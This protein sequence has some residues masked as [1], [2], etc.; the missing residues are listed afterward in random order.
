[1]LILTRRR[2]QA[3]MIGDTVS[4]TVLGIRGNQVRLGIDAPPNVAIHRREIWERIQNQQQQEGG[5]SPRESDR[6][7]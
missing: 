2:K 7:G 3:V 6:N 4:I 1:M 5:G